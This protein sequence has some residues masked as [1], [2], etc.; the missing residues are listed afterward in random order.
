MF[1]NRLEETKFQ[2]IDNFTRVM[3]EH[4][5]KVGGNLLFTQ[6][7]NQFQSPGAQNQ[8]A[9]EFRFASLDDFR[10]FRASSYFRPF[11][12]GGGHRA[13]HVRRRRMG[14]LCAGRVAGDAQAHSHTRLALRPAIIPG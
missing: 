13:G 6:Y 10:N 7:L 9:G 12:E 4:T 3:G 8:G 2:L 1:N 11:E 14:D 5:I